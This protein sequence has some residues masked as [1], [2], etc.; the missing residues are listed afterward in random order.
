MVRPP[1]FA[2]G[3]LTNALIDQADDRG[4]GGREIADHVLA[5]VI[6]GLFSGVSDPALDSVP[7][8]A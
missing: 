8:H 4:A 6:T 7:A 1:G 2:G 5:I 3:S